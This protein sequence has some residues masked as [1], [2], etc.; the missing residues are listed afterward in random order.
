MSNTDKHINHMNSMS[1][2]YFLLRAYQFNKNLRRPSNQEFLNLI[3]AE[4]GNRHSWLPKA[5]KQLDDIKERLDKAISIFISKLKDRET[6]EKL[7]DLQ[8]R[9]SEVSSNREIPSLV[10][11]GLNL[12][13][14]F[15]K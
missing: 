12:T 10:D 4:N 11:E 1:Y 13:Q 15:V 6:I 2:E 7:E 8:S 3:E 9:I 5:E 14:T